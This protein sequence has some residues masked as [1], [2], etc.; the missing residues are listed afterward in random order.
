VFVASGDS[1]PM[2]P[3]RYSHQLAGLIPHASF[4]IYSDSAHGFLFQH[5]ADFAADVSHFLGASP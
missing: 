4:K 3:P 1:D 5:H 2:I